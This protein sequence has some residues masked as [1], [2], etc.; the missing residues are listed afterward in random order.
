MGNVRMFPRWP[1]DDEEWQEAVD[2]ASLM[3]HL[4][5]AKLYGLIDWK[6]TVN[7]AQCER[8][9]R[10]GRDR[11]TTPAPIEELLHRYIIAGD[12]AGDDAT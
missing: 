4:H 2:S 11:G 3:L 10:E 6:V 1:S 5:D 9:I 7:V 8:L 12:R